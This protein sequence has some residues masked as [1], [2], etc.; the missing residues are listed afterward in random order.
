V[1]TA[2]AV[3]AVVVIIAGTP[4]VL[5]ASAGTPNSC[6]APGKRIHWVVDYCMLKMETDD[7]IAVSG[8]IEKEARRRVRNACASNTYFKRRMCETMIRNGSRAGTVAQC[9]KDRSFKGR[10]V[11]AGGVGG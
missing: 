4:S 10:T 2:I 8:C 9:L 1:N 6:V 11:E 5:A 3:L 7:E